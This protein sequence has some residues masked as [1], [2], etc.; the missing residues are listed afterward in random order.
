MINYTIGGISGG[1]VDL[2]RYNN[3]KRAV[4]FQ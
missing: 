3:Q 4:T 2:K 1:H